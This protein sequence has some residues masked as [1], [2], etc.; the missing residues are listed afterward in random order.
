[1]PR[2][3]SLWIDR[4]AVY[5]VHCLVSVAKM[6]T[7]KSLPRYNVLGEGIH[8]GKILADYIRAISMRMDDSK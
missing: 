7:L 2:G 3:P 4:G 8:R 5:T 1:M 6:C